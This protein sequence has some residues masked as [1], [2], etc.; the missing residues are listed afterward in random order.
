MMLNVFLLLFL[1]LW[2]INYQSW[3]LICTYTYAGS[4]QPFPFLPLKYL[5]TCFSV[6]SPHG[7][8]LHQD[9]Y[10]CH[11]ITIKPPFQNNVCQVPVVWHSW[12]KLGAATPMMK[13]Y[14]HGSPL[15]PPL[16]LSLLVTC[17]TSALHT[18]WWLLWA[19]SPLLRKKL[20]LGTCPAV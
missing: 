7:E 5:C 19:T 18:C 1:L 13:S 17:C 4:A 16:H 3:I 9:S 15:G 10:S 6:S 14:C 11:W 2:T 12:V 8:M 20:V